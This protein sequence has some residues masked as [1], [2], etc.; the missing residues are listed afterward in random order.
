LDLQ[1]IFGC[2]VTTAR[3]NRRETGQALEGTPVEQ[4]RLVPVG[5]KLLDQ[6]DDEHVIS[7]AVHVLHHAPEVGGAP[8][9]V[10]HA[11]PHLPRGARHWLR[12]SG[13]VQREVALA[14]AQHVHR[15]RR[16]GSQRRGGP[17]LPAKRDQ[18]ERRVKR[19][20][21]ERVHGRP[22]ELVHPFGSVGHDGDA[23]GEVPQ[24]APEL[25]LVDGSETCPV[26]RR[27]DHALDR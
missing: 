25:R 12:P 6:A 24:R 16:P 7:R 4:E 9:E 10:R 5:L 26:V 27:D 15:V 2:P 1:L 8:G 13:E 17:G 11:G 21:S 19:H 22:A 20:G 3:G 18:H 14:V 23:G